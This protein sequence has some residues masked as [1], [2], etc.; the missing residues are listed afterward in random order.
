MAAVVT[1]PGVMPGRV[2]VPISMAVAVAVAVAM[3]TI[4]IVP[5]AVVPAVPVTDAHRIVPTMMGSMRVRAMARERRGRHQQREGDPR[6]K[7]QL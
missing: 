7:A 3:A 2:A 5:A 4:A 1:V 6:Q